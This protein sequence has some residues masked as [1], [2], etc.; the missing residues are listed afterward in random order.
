[1]FTAVRMTRAWQQALREGLAQARAFNRPLVVAKRERLADAPDLLE[2]FAAAETRAQRRFLVARPDDGF[3]LLGLGV[4]KEIVATRPEPFAEVRARARALLHGAEPGALLLGGFAFVPLPQAKRSSAWRSR[5]NAR[6][7]LPALIYRCEGSAAWLTRIA[8]VHPAEREPALMERW[9]RAACELLEKPQPVGARDRRLETD[10]DADAAPRYA[11]SAKEI[12]AAIRRGEADKVVLARVERLQLEHG[13]S[14]SSVLRQL[15]QSHSSSFV[16]AD[17]LA[18][19]TFLGATPERLVQRSGD[20]VVTS[21]VA[22]TVAHGDSEPGTAQLACALRRSPKERAE[23]AFVVRALEE[24]LSPL[25]RELVVP[26]A[27]DL[28]DTGTVQH[29]STVIRG[30][31]TQPTHVL[32]L[33]ARL[34]PTP[35]V[36]GTPRERAL[37][38]IHKHER[39]DRGG[40]AAPIG[41]FDV[42]GDGEFVVALRCGLFRHDQIQLFAGAGLVAGSDPEREAAETTLKLRTL[43]GALE[44]TCNA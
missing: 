19:E 24:G 11:E 3:A 40:Y 31:L 5:A 20:A 4:T 28:L 35:A 39:F 29:L 34:H 8:R 2:L 38:L 17:G 36:A 27:P 1:M 7:V 21:A 41:F 14:A 42:R 13:L 16:F 9:E 15:Y 32:E 10:F 30:K 6:F 23:H 12:I 25:C 22:G 37:E 44:A 33:V 43:R 26:H 18:H